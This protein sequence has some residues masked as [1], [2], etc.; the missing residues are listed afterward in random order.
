MLIP[1]FGELIGATG[2]AALAGIAY[3]SGYPFILL[4][5]LFGLLVGC[6]SLFSLSLGESKHGAK[7]VF[8]YSLVTI[9]CAITG[10]YAASKIRDFGA[11][12]LVQRAQ[13]LITA[14]EKYENEKHCVPEKSRATSAEV[15][16]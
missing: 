3:I 13:P 6:L 16:I 10:F 8:L 15:H 2:I 12:I 7:L 4:T 14:I 9:V 11:Y 1:I 5:V